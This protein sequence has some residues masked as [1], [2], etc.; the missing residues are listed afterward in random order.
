MSRPR[1]RAT[2]TRATSSDV[3]RTARHC[4]MTRKKKVA[5]GPLYPRLTPAGFTR[6]HRVAAA[7]VRCECCA[8][9][10]HQVCEMASGS[11][12]ALGVNKGASHMNSELMYAESDRKCKKTS[13]KEAELQISGAHLFD[14]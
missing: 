9:G 14:D 4:E 7:S 12:V 11:R 6:T 2:N 13:R 10:D 5:P 3:E 1:T 8:R